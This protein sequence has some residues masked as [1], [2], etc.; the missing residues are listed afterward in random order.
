MVSHLHPANAM[1]LPRLRD[2]GLMEFDQAKEAIAEG[3][4]CVE[5]PLRCCS[6]TCKKTT[7]TDAGAIA[8]VSTSTKVGT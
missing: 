2:I 3:R 4:I 5:Q 7:A 8:L 1:L 6:V